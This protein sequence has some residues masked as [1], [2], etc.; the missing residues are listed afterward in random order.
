LIYSLVADPAHRHRGLERHNV[1]RTSDWLKLREENKV[2]LI[3]LEGM[4]AVVKFYG[5]GGCAR[6]LR[7]VM[8]HF[9]AG[10]AE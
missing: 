2:K 5:A 8:S 4:M 6:E 10:K 7:D 9:L 1:N 3:I